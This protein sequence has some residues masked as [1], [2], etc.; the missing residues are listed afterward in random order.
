MALTAQ[1]Q[2]IFHKDTKI[3]GTESLPDGPSAE[4]RR[5]MVDFVGNPDC[6]LYRFIGNDHAKRKLAEAA[7][8]ALKRGNH[9]CRELAV[10][11][12]G[13]A[14]VGKTTLMKLFAELLDLP[15]VEISPR[16]IVNVNDLFASICSQ[17]NDEGVPIKPV[18][19]SKH[20]RLPP[21]IIFVDEVHGLSQKVVDALL[22]ACESKDCTLVTERGEVI[23]CHDVC[24]G[25]ATTESGDLFDAFES[26]FDEVQ[27]RYY[28]RE[29]LARIVAINNPDLTPEVC[30]L[31]AKFQR[32][33][34]KLLR[35]AQSMRNKREMNTS[36]AWEQIALEVAKDNGIDEHGMALKHVEILKSLRV[37][38]VAKD[39][40]PIMIG[41]KKPELEKK[42]MPLLLC[43]T[44]DQ[45]ALVEVGSDG[46]RLTEAGHNELNKREGV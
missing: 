16:S 2:A 17:M 30:K 9:C 19:D 40:L 42:L 45:P 27:L 36:M 23:N 18:R 8:V 5:Q 34:R 20:F 33:P 7:F 29:E 1:V 22:K 14:S 38:P 28:T 3:K 25:I 10:F 44:A 21:C 43:S 11:L 24:W 39:R 6:P 32:L 13:P 26:R 12:S 41:V 4:E 37:K 31:I 46:Y 35:F 15:F